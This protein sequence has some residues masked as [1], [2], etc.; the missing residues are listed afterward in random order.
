MLLY[1][2][3]IDEIDTKLQKIDGII[4]ALFQTNKNMNTAI[5]Y[6]PEYFITSFS[7]NVPGILFENG[8][9]HLKTIFFNGSSV[10]LYIKNKLDFI[11]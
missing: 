4:M 8:L 9:L 7:E 6:M 3:K 1:L 5:S 11:L 10:L 2:N